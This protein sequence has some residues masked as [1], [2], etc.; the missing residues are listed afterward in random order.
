MTETASRWRRGWWLAAVPVLIT[1]VVVVLTWPDGESAPDRLEVES[2]APRFDDL[3]SLA[4]A[5]DLVVVGG[6][7]RVGPGRVVTAPDDPETGI[8]TQLADVSVDEVLAGSEVD[9]VVLEEEAELLDGTPI[10]VDGAPPVE[11]GEEGVWFLIRSPDPELPYVAV[12]GPQGRYRLDGDAL[13]PVVPD[14]LTEE[15]A[16]LGLD[17]L[18]RELSDRG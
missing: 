13:E 16:A 9:A 15:V 3:R 7:D 5:A 10:A 18:R 1:V 4:A 17:G 11:T 2:S 12:V 6:V 14:A 8:R